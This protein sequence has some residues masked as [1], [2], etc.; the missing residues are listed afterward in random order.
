MVFVNTNKVG[1]GSIYCQ[2]AISEI[3]IENILL[4]NIEVETTSFDQI[5]EKKKINK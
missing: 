4:I 5:L 2:C 1:T 3:N